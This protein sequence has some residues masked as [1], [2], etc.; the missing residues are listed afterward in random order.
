MQ[1]AE[2]DGSRQ[3]KAAHSGGTRPLIELVDVTVRY[4]AGASSVLAVEGLSLAIPATG[5]V[6]I[7][8]RSG[9]GKS[10]VLNLIAGSRL[11]T[12]GRVEINGQPIVGPERD[13]MVV[14]QQ[15]TT[16][17]P[18]FDAERNVALALTA[19]GKSKAE[20]REGARHYLSIVGLSGFESTPIYM[21]NRSVD[22]ALYVSTEVVSMSARPGRILHRQGF[23]YNRATRESGNSH[24]RASLEGCV[25]TSWSARVRLERADCKRDL[26]LFNL[27]VHKKT[28][29]LRSGPP[30]S[31]RRLCGKPYKGARF[32]HAEYCAQA[33]GLLCARSGCSIRHLVCRFAGN[34]HA[35]T[36]TIQLWAAS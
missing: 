2:T 16:L 20:A 13:R 14:H 25:Q 22:E 23:D 7:I 8:G 15:T 18:C 34:C 5:S 4:G 12:S 24:I 3:A 28:P 9:C 19:R 1:D 11:P 33:T 35:E 32:D 30:G 31:A 10:S 27:D 17:L 29:R 6:T 36:D 21:I 26:A